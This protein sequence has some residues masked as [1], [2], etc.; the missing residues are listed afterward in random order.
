M[1]ACIVTVWDCDRSMA[2]MFTY[3]HTKSDQSLTVQLHSLTPVVN[4]QTA[5]RLAGK[6]SIKNGLNLG[7]SEVL[8]SFR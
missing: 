6:V 7:W 4:G 5:D 2:D 8:R 1:P 3:T